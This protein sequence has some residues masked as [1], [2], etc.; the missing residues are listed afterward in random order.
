MARPPLPVGTAG[1][2]SFLSMP[3]GTVR[4]RALFRDYDGV[5]RPVSRYGR[6]RAAAERAL[7]EALRD[8]SGPTAGQITSTAR[9]RDVARTWMSEVEVSDLAG[10]TVEVYQRTLDKHVVPGLGGLQLR[11]VDVPA[12][13]RFL[14][15]VRQH[16]GAGAA[17]TTKNV[18]SLMLG[19]AARLGAIPTNPV[20]DSGKISRGHRERPRAL[21]TV[22]VD[23]LVKVARE[24]SADLGDLVE[25]MLGSGMRIGEA[26]AIRSEVVDLAAGVIEVNA[27]NV[28]LKG[29]GTVLQSRTK[30]DAG[31]RVIAVPDHVAVL[32][33]RR[34]DA[35]VVRSEYRLAFPNYL[36]RPQNPSNVQR[37]LRSILDRHG[38]EWVTTHTFRKTVATRLDEAGMSARAIADH[39]GHAKPSMT[40]D[41]YMGRGVASAE[42]AKVLR[43]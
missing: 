13:D 41:V 24:T 9:V 35:P 1:R 29:K 21:T 19:Y 33:G 8:R 3:N 22:E 34:L 16:H 38:F 5:T 14:K 37:S 4:A 26:L 31:W 6:S 23:Q 39:L 32:L 17:R 18:T 36:G 28:R 43:R 40:Q 10:G 20:R 15:S 30:T 11:E 2:T 27:T 7:K 12:V 25:T 42:A